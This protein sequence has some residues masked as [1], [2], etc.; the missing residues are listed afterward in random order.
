M[1]LRTFIRSYCLNSRLATNALTRLHKALSSLAGYLAQQGFDSKHGRPP[2]TKP[3]WTVALTPSA[4]SW[5]PLCSATPA[6]ASSL[7][8]HSAGSSL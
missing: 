8:T 5:P 7:S 6:K 1:N 4:Q 2:V 3:R